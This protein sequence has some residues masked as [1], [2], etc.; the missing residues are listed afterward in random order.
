M[1][2]LPTSRGALARPL[3]DPRQE[4][5]GDRASPLTRTRHDGLGNQV[6][7][8]SD[9]AGALLHHRGVRAPGVERG[10]C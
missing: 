8:R 5:P 7:D 1:P 6:L 3:A 2:A 4:G 9:P 10:W